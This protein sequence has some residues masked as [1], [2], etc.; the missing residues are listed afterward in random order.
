MLGLIALAPLG[1]ASARAQV[2]PACFDPAALPASQKG[3]RKALG[4]QNVSSNPARH[5]A[6]C[7]FFAMTKPA[8]CGT[9][10]LLSGGPVSA[11][12]V[13]NSFAKKG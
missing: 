8:N 10:A 6:A 9:C 12:S 4:F 2:A 7:A 1:I 13:C 11:A 3:I 5:C